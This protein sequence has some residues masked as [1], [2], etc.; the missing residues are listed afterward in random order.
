MPSMII[1]H[2]KISR[3]FPEKHACKKYLSLGTTPNIPLAQD[4]VEI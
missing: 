4:A 1:P 2:E 3:Q